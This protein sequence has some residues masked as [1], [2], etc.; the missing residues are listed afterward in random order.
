MTIQ[1][2]SGGNFGGIRN[3]KIDYVENVTDILSVPNSAIDLLAREGSSSA[4]T[5]PQT[6]NAGIIYETKCQGF[7][8]GIDETNL[9]GFMAYQNRKIIAWIED[10]HGNQFAIGKLTEPA[11]VL[12]ETNMPGDVKT[13]HGFNFTITCRQ[14]TPVAVL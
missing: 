13:A 6:T 14:T 7:T 5:S 11:R 10:Y 12:I 3:I 9:A 1:K 4:T 2:I 8:P